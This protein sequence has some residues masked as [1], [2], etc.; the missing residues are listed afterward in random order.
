MASQ[1]DHATYNNKNNTDI[2]SQEEDNNRST[3]GN[4][5]TAQSY[6]Q[7][8]KFSELKTKTKN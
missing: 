3:Y 5:H 7:I 1:K 8:P 2:S 6:G 4:Y